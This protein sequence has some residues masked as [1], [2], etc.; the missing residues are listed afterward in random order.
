MMRRLLKIQEAADYIGIS[1]DK[2]RDWIAK[3]RIPFKNVS[4]GKKA[5]FRF[6]L[7]E[8]DRWIDQLPGHNAKD[9]ET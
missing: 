6:D 4:M 1:P 7:R 5:I 8:L 9:I 3:R 2:I